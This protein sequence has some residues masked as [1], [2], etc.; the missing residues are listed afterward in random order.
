VAVGATLSLLA[1]AILSTVLSPD[2][3]T[4]ATVLLHGILEPAA[5]AGAL[6]ALRP[7]RR[8]LAVVAIVL[9]VSVAI[10]GL[11]NMI[12]TLPTTHSLSVL[13]AQRLLFSRITYFNVGLFGEM[14]AMATPLLLGALLGRRRLGLSRAVVAALVVVTLVALA[15]LFLTFSKSAYLATA[16]G[17]LVLLLL[18]VRGWRRRATI[19]VT[20]GL[21]SAV[22]I[23]WPAFFLQ[24]SPPLENA[25]RT[26]VVSLV[27][28]S[29][30]DSWNPSTLSGR[31]SLL[32]RWY[33]TRAAVQMAV[34]HPILGIGLDQFQEQYVV[35]R[36]RPPEAHLALD[37]AHSQWAELAAELGFPALALVLVIY[38]AAM[39]ALLRAYRAPPDETTRLLAAALLASM[40]GWL[41]VATAFAGDMYRAWR[42][43]ASDYVMM[44]VLVA[45]AFALYHLARTPTDGP[46][47][48]TAGGSVTPTK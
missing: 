18:V 32:E 19:V 46:P 36:Y 34:D 5:M 38:G 35:G 12:Q 43:M 21:V 4:S 6:L 29:R 1:L 27:G 17:S 45:A 31:G 25:Y 20:A 41:M 22:V 14:L 2:V 15:G 40:T 37:S 10:G 44:M 26:A 33:A 16:G 24:V 9:G 23:P 47:A 7:T 48:A 42:N 8:Y 13:Q 11:L 28:Q 3:Q 39:L 30:Y